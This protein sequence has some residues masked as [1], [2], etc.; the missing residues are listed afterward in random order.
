MINL[1][2]NKSLSFNVY[3]PNLP[4]RK[5]RKAH[6]QNEFNDRNEFYPHI[7]P[8]ITHQF[9]T[10][11]LWKTIQYILRDLV[12]EDEEFVI[13]C[14]DDHQFTSVY[15]SHKLMEKINKAQEIGADI[16]LGGVSWF[17]DAVQISRDLFW[18]EK[19]SGLQFTIIFKKFYEKI[20]N[21]SFLETDAADYKISALSDKKFIIYPFISIQKE[22][23]YSDVTSKNAEPGFVESC[24]KETSERLQL[25]KNVKTYYK[26]I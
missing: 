13:I 26:S 10:V 7:I 23:G 22:F 15:Q 21:A 1:F 16:L 20:L 17:K 3:V 4:E 12:N 19:F 9:G 11:G 25:L 2:D 14:E 18:V 24:F 6:I 8:A 5:E